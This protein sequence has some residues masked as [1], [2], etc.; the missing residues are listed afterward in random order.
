MKLVN[1]LLLISLCILVPIRIPDIYSTTFPTI[2]DAPIVQK[3][4]NFPP[5][6]SM[7]HVGV[8]LGVEVG[9]PVYAVRDGIVLFSGID[10]VYGRC[11]MILHFDGYASVYGHLSISFVKKGNYVHWGKII[12]LSGG[13]PDKDPEGSGQSSGPH[14]HFEIRVPDHLDNNKYNIDPLKYLGLEN[15]K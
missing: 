8:D 13:D 3:F 7:P 1:I 10:K 12:G 9:T 14:L 5:G 15:E 4:G 2:P 11:I 6:A